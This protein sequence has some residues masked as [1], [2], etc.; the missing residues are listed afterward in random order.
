[1]SQ[2]VITNIILFCCL[3]P[4]TKF[5]QPKSLNI[6]ELNNKYIYS[7]TVISQLHLVLIT[8]NNGYKHP[9]V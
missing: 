7:L 9:I 6:F 2:D 5:F 4:Q 1:M 3:L 8:G